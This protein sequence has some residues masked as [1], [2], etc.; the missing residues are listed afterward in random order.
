[1]L[2]IRYMCLARNQVLFMKISRTL[3]QDGCRRLGGFH[4]IKAH[5]WTSLAR[6]TPGTVCN[7]Y[8]KGRMVEMS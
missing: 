2:C 3:K 6:E 1:M 5:G 4:V 8:I 7:L